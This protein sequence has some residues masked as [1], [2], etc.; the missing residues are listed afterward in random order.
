MKR[1]TIRLMI[2][3]LL[4]GLVLLSCSNEI[5][6]NSSGDGIAKVVFTT[7][8]EATTKGLSSSTIAFEN[9]DNLY[10]YYTAAKEDMGNTTGEALE[11]VKINEDGTG[12]GNNIFQFSE[13][14]WKF[15]L[16]GY[17]DSDRKNRVYEGIKSATVKKD[18]ENVVRIPIEHVATSS[19]TG[20]LKVEASISALKGVDY[21]IKVTIKSTSLEESVDATVESGKITLEKD[22]KEGIYAITFIPSVNDTQMDDVSLPVEI[23]A[24][25]DTTISGDIDTLNG[26][27]IDATGDE[28]IITLADTS[29]EALRS[30]ISAAEKYSIATGKTT[31]VKLSGSVDIGSESI[32]ITSGNVK[33]DLN[34]SNITATGTAITVDEEGTSVEICDTSENK[35]GKISAKVGVE[36]KNGQFDIESGSIEASDRGIIVREDG[37]A[38]V[39]GSAIVSV[40]GDGI[41]VENYGSTII[42]G[43]ATIKAENG[44]ALYVKGGT[45]V[46][47][48][49][50]SIS[51]ESGSAITIDKESSA[52][53]A[54]VTVAG[55]SVVA[56]NGN[57]TVNVKNGEYSQ[58]GTSTV[59]NSS[60]EGVVIDVESVSKATISGGTVKAEGTAV[61]IRTSGFTKISG[62]NVTAAAGEAIA[63]D[64]ETTSI[65]SGNVTSAGGATI[66]VNDGELN[67]SGGAISNTSSDIDDSAAIDSNGGATTIKGGSVTS[68][69]FSIDNSDNTTTK[70]SAISINPDAGDTATVTGSSDYKVTYKANGPESVSDVA[71]VKYKGVSLTIAE[72]SFSYDKH[73]FLTWKDS[74]GI[75]YSVGSKYADDKSLELLAQWES[76]YTVTISVESDMTK[77]SDIDD[78]KAGATVTLPEIADK[79]GYSAEWAASDSQ[80]N[81]IEIVNGAITMPADNV[82][83][84]ATWKVHT[85][86]VT[87]RNDGNTKEEKDITVAY[88][89]TVNITTATSDYTLEK[90]GYDFDGWTAIAGG[91]DNVN[92]SKSG[93]NYTFTMPDASVVVTAK[94]V[95]VAR[96]ITLY[97]EDGTT[98]LKTIAS[99]TGAA[100]NLTASDFKVEK[101]YYTP[102]E[103][104][105][106]SGISDSDITDNKFTMPNN[107]VSFKVS[108]WDKVYYSITV[109][110]DDGITPETTT[111]EDVQWGENVTIPSYEDTKSSSL[112]VAKYVIYRDSNDVYQYPTITDSVFEMPKSDVTIWYK[113]PEKIGGI[114]FY[115]NESVLNDN[116]HYT[117]YD[118]DMNVVGGGKDVSFSDSESGAKT[119][120]AITSASTYYTL[121]GG[122]KDDTKD[123][124]YVM[125]PKGL[126][127]SDAAYWG[128]PTTSITFASDKSIGSGR[129]NTEAIMAY[130]KAGNSCGSKTTYPYMWDLYKAFIAEDS[131]TND[132]GLYDWYIPSYDELAKYAEYEKGGGT[133]IVTRESWCST[134]S[135]GSGSTKVVYAYYNREM[136]SWRADTA[137]SGVYVV[138]SF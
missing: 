120:A 41:A 60:D 22:L 56:T 71:V 136:S 42:D 9:P 4:A 119:L 27:T 70:D 68:T 6:G 129:T 79:T 11:E 83:L 127:S 97:D 44:D 76:L 45:T 124:C 86:S 51:S 43:N 30:A 36:V 35:S 122:K 107:D 137:F 3:A 61:G 112:G 15:S 52:E 74:A 58:Q 105:A 24:G 20:T 106:V 33:I 49:S 134:R 81:N 115:I 118:A 110:Y 80:G 67:I 65:L 18:V 2:I 50:A 14:D 37:V 40:L 10:W 64:G 69:H 113:Y 123:W 72:N 111:I 31:V 57:I 90:N 32:D 85:F 62:G 96:N 93:D 12:L 126:A 94:Y 114:V 103:W 117:F 55:S 66:I 8:K 53:S 17:S 135:A 121:E 98:E 28:A 23:I 132:S 46:I 92:I 13:G 59:S 47:N 25:Q 73:E 116:A 77:P 54:F 34:G 99:N 78:Q 128:F 100:I 29:A 38:G 91:T 89:E 104:T 75:E 7:G 131:T 138:R 95:G 88:G 26:W 108:K 16:F 5:A 102:G 19:E 82:T 125:Y 48:D 84:T 87:L 1:N 109:K 101:D 130:I 63:V 21:T 133:T 39:G